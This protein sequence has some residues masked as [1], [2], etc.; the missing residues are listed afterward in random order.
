MQ[1]AGCFHTFST[2][3]RVSLENPL[4]VSWQVRQQALQPVVLTWH[5]VSTASGHVSV[6]RAVASCSNST[7]DAS[8]PVSVPEAVVKGHAHAHGGR[9]DEPR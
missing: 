3:I 5:V 8:L 9:L 6:V 7:R 1:C 4:F 2:P